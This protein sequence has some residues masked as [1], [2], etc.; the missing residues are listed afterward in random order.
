MAGFAFVR[1]VDFVPVF[2]AARGFA[3]AGGDSSAPCRSDDLFRCRKSSGEGNY[4]CSGRGRF[5]SGAIRTGDAGF[6]CCGRSG[7]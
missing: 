3:D 2:G 4:A 6:I 5:D 1:A 7:H